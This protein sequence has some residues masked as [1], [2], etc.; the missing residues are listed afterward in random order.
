M[1]CD[2][3]SLDSFLLLVIKQN[4]VLEGQIRKVHPMQNYSK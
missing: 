1:K 3:K 4:I 2:K